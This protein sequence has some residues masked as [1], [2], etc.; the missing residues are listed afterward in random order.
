MGSERCVYLFC[1]LPMPPG[2]SRCNYAK[3]NALAGDIT[4]VRDTVEGG[5]DADREQRVA[6]LYCVERVT[7]LLYGC[8]AAN[9]SCKCM[10]GG[11][12]WSKRQKSSSKAPSGRSRPLNWSARG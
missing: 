2:K 1:D 8:V 9:L 10:V 7:P 12:C 3:R 6:L 4:E 11:K 5:V